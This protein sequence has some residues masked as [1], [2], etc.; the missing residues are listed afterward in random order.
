MDCRQYPIDVAALAY[1]AVFSISPL[2]IIALGIIGRFFDKKGT[3]YVQSQLGDLVR[4]LNVR[5]LGVA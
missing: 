5:I 2:L 4:K 3:E 1:Y